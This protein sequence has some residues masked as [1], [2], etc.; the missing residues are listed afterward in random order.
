[1]IF[2][3]NFRIVTLIIRLKSNSKT[4]SCS[5]KYAFLLAAIFYLWFLYFLILVYILENR[6]AIHKK[7]QY[8]LYSYVQSQFYPL[9]LFVWINNS[10]TCNVT[11]VFID[12]ILVVH[13]GPSILKELKLFCVKSMTWQTYLCLLQYILEMSKLT[14]VSPGN[15]KNYMLENLKMMLQQSKHLEKA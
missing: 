13:T 14:G 4:C 9:S 7:K 15:T 5:A 10:C 11:A 8:H 1:M 6:K 12:F 2:K 3:V